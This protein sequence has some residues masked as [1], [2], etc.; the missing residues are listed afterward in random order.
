[1]KANAGKAC[2]ISW[3]NVVK[4]LA[5]TNPMIQAMAN[6]IPKRVPIKGRLMKI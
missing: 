6:K 3:M 2:P 5:K 1:V 4:I